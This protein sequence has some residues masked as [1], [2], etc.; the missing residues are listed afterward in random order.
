MYESDPG[1]DGTDE[2]DLSEEEDNPD[3]GFVSEKTS[4]RMMTRSQLTSY[5]DFP[6][7]SSS[8]TKKMKK[9]TKIVAS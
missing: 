5:F 3:S 8:L 2:T 9:T 6:L 4:R 1:T 7:T